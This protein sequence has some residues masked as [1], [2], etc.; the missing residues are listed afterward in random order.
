MA[1]LA[2]SRTCLSFTVNYPS[3]GE[4]VGRVSDHGEH[5]P[6]RACELV[7]VPVFLSALNHMKSG[8]PQRRQTATKA[9]SIQGGMESWGIPAVGKGVG[10]P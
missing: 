5:V 6:I 7:S 1:V 2:P 10:I 3:V 8:M 4:L 9:L